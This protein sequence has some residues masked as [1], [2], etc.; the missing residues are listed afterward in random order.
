MH[1]RH[2][3][4]D[5][6]FCLALC[7]LCN[8]HCLD[9]DPCT[10]LRAYDHAI[11]CAVCVREHVRIDPHTNM[12]MLASDALLYHW[13]PCIK[14]AP[15]F[16]SGMVETVVARH[17]FDDV[18]LDVQRGWCVG[19]YEVRTLESLVAYFCWLHD[20]DIVESLEQ[21]NMD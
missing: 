16:A 21:V 1:M 3:A 17:G 18:H 6:I 20:W 12:Y 4:D 15:S 9:D 14:W 19:R 10:I 5:V 2:V 13:M 7:F 11:D 8:S